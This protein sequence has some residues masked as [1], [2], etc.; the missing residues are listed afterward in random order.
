MVTCRAF[1]QFLKLVSSP[2]RSYHHYRNIQYA[3]F[4]Q[5]TARPSF[6]ILPAST[7]QQLAGETILHLFHTIFQQ[8][9]SNIKAFC[10]QIE[11]CQLVQICKQVGYTSWQIV[12]HMLAGWQNCSSILP[13]QQQICILDRICI[14][15]MAS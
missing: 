14:V 3:V 8:F 13:G 15:T 6:I 9:S 7:F 4:F 11:T 10:S 2:I 5:R 12:I 1:C